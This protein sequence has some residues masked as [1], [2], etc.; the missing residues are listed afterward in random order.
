MWGLYSGTSCT[1]PD[2]FLIMCCPTKY[3]QPPIGWVTVMVT[4]EA[5]AQILRGG[6]L[7]L[8]QMEIGFIATFVKERKIYH[9]RKYPNGAGKHQNRLWCVFI[10]LSCLIDRQAPWFQR[11]DFSSSSFWP[12]HPWVSSNVTGSISSNI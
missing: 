1:M 7:K 10:Q 8:A 6:K 11:E 3:S 12:V 4:R 2:L 5:W 9:Q